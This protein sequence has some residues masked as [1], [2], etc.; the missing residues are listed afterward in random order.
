MERIIEQRKN[1]CRIVF[2]WSFLLLV[3]NVGGQPIRQTIQKVYSA[4]IGVRE[5]TGNND[6]QR[7]EMYLATTGLG[8]GYPWCAAFVT[9]TMIQAKVKTPHSAY[10]PDWFISNVIYKQTWQKTYPEAKPGMV[11]GLYFA[12]K[13]RI[14]HVGFIDGEDHN[15]Y[16][17]VEGNTNEAGSR[18]GDGVYRKIRPKNTVYVIADYVLS[19]N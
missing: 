10:S 7:V 9:W 4:E 1:I 12:S 16:Y 8:K 19:E 11:F 13:K 14:A 2:I 15:N 5:Q 6:G 3:C 17:T 18:E